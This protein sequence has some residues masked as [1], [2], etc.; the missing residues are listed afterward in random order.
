MG[1]QEI[2]KFDIIIGFNSTMVGEHF[3]NFEPQLP[4]NAMDIHEICK[5]DITIASNS[6]MIEE[7]FDNF[8]VVGQIR[9]NF[10]QNWLIG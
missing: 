6:T 4:K 1:T 10:L 3:E 2:W 7:V 8:V 9:C 5:F